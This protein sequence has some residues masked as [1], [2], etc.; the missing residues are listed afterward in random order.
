MY[1]KAKQDEFRKEV[2]EKEGLPESLGID[3]STKCGMMAP[4][5]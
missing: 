3:D 4:N 5:C 2:S 1:D